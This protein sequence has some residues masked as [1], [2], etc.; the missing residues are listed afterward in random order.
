MGGVGEIN[1]FTG[2]FLF[3]EYYYSSSLSPVIAVK[4]RSSVQ[5]AFIFPAQHAEFLQLQH[6]SQLTITLPDNACPQTS[7]DDMYT[8]SC[9][10][11]FDQF[12]PERE[13]TVTSGD[14]PLITPVGKAMLRRKKTIDAC[15]AH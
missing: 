3:C 4:K 5:K 2:E 15:W 12:Y 6:I 14:P 9:A 8:T 1:G 7:F 13:I 11:L 10:T